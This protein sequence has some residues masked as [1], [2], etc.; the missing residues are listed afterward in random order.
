MELFLSSESSLR[1]SL[2]LLL[3]LTFLALEWQFPKLNRPAER[4]T[5]WTQHFS[6]SLLNTFILRLLFPALALN[7]A[8]NP[9]ISW[10]LFNFVN[11]P[12]WL[13]TLFSLLILDCA[14]Y[15]QHRLFH[16]IPFFWS[17]HRMH[18]SD[19]VLDTSTALRFHP[20]EIVVS[21]VFKILVV[22]LLGI[23]PIAVVLFE[24]ALNGTALFNHSNWKLGF[25]DS[26]LKVLLV[27]PDMHRIHHSSHTPETN[28]NYGFCLSLWDRLFLSF[29]EGP[30]PEEIG[31]KEFRKPSEQKFWRLLAQPFQKIPK[32]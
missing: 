26:T 8:L 23:S 7:F 18:H 32:I 6:L 24:I 25:A 1:F 10:G 12:I 22:T 19:L 30:D 16:R 20:I 28:S 31:L 29:K 3:L 2:F 15:W 5:R 17:I 14:I 9:P 21:M 27:T 13:E 4:L 11:Y